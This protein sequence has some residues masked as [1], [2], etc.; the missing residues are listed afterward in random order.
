ML[1]KLKDITDDKDI[2]INLS[3]CEYINF[4][5]DKYSITIQRPGV[6]FHVINLGESQYHEFKHK[7]NTFSILKGGLMNNDKKTTLFGFIQSA[8]LTGLAGFSYFSGMDVTGISGQTS[9]A[10]DW[11]ALILVAIAIFSAIK[12]YYTNKVD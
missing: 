4:N 5:P 10:G 3:L 12:S 1:I 2:L 8:L 11:G 7:V 6:R 9:S